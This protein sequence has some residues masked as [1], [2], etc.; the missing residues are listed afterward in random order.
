MKK[1]FSIIAV[2]AIAISALTTSACALSSPAENARYCA[3]NS[4]HYGM[5]IVRLVHA[6][7][8][9]THDD[10]CVTLKD[11]RDGNLYAIDDDSLVKG[12][13][14]LIA[15]DDNA[16]PGFVYDDMIIGF[17]NGSALK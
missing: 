9:A 6:T 12:E 7:V 8:T 1:F 4:I 11:M 14:V 16:T 13:D 5:N 15:I 3:T 17:W 10:G 2:L